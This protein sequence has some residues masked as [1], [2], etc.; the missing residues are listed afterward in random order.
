MQK[1]KTGVSSAAR[2]RIHVGQRIIKT[3]ISVYLCA[4]IGYFRGQPTYFSIIAAI[5]CTQNST[6][7]S[8]TTSLNRIL[9]TLVGGFFGLATLY[10]CRYTGITQLL[11][12]YY[13]IIAVLIIPIILVTLLIDKPAISAFSCVVFLSITVS[14]ISDEAPLLYAFNRILDT[15]VGVGVTLVINLVLPGVVRKV[16]SSAEGEKKED[17]GDILENLDFIQEQPQETETEVEAMERTEAES[18]K[19]EEKSDDE[20]R[21]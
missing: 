9:G 3:A 19:T 7:K 21:E 14:H 11:P 6:D 8:L 16:K 17:L 2:P 10:V 1:N 20:K 4:L 12:V 18:E 13:F 15:L 5:M